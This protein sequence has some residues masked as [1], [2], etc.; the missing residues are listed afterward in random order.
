[1]VGNVIPLHRLTHPEEPVY[2]NP[3]LIAM[4]ESTPDTVISLTNASK[5]VVAESAEEVTALV[6]D[7]RARVVSRAI[8]GVGAQPERARSRASPRC[9]TC[10]S[11]PHDRE[12]LDSGLKAHGSEPMITQRPTNCSSQTTP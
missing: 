1:M 4:I 12:V 11:I 2:V 6:C 9:R 5:L 7:W 8:E 3:D 10:Q